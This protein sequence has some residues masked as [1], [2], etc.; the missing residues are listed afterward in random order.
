[1]PPLVL[2]VI[3]RNDKMER[4]SLQKYPPTLWIERQQ[5]YSLGQND[6]LR[7]LEYTDSF[8]YLYG[9]HHL[10]P[11]PSISLRNL[12]LKKFFSAFYTGSWISA[13]ISNVTFMLGLAAL[14]L[15]YIIT[16][17]KVTVIQCRLEVIFVIIAQQLSDKQ[18]HQTFS[19][20]TVILYFVTGLCRWQCRYHNNR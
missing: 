4:E 20:C 7:G 9:V 19:S 18:T 8:H 12:F 3:V 14:Q 5:T 13:T 2:I 16:Y 17:L 11:G 6:H 1:M 15:W 10:I